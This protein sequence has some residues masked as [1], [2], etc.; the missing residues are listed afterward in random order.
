MHGDYELITIKE[1]CSLI[2]GKAKPVSAAT[3]YRGVAAG[4]Y[5]PPVHPSPGVSRLRKAK[6]LDDIARQIGEGASDDGA[7]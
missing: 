1:G 3:F 7:T 5:T 4:R 2:G 6:L